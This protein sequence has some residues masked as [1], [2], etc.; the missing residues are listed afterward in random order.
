MAISLVTGHAGYSHIT[1]Q[2]AAQRN[3]G[4]SS[5][6]VRWASAAP[7]MTVKS[8]SVTIGDFLLVVDGRYVKNDGDESVSFTGGSSGYSRHDILALRYYVNDTDDDATENVE[9]RI[10]PGAAVGYDGITDDATDPTVSRVDLS[11]LPKSSD[12]AIARIRLLGTSV[13]VESLIGES[14][15]SVADIVDYMTVPNGRKVRTYSA[16][17]SGADLDD[18]LYVGH[19]SGTGVTMRTARSAGFTGYIHTMSIETQLNPSRTRGHIAARINLDPSKSFDIRAVDEEAYYIDTGVRMT[20]PD[21]WSGGYHRY[22]ICGYSIANC[23]ENAIATTNWCDS[24]DIDISDEG[25][26][27]VRATIDTT[28]YSAIIIVNATISTASIREAATL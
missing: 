23:S 20:I 2:Q 3:I 1:S 9:L 4:V 11:L 24:A 17:I 5:H 14:I 7:S 25:A 16:D 26:V 18:V 15:V 10:I 21:G 22:D 6:D 13:S 28:I 19:G 27:Y 8:T 12:V